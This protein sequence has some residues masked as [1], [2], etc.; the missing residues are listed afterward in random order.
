MISAH[1]DTPSSKKSIEQ[2]PQIKA[3]E[4]LSLFYEIETGGLFSNK[5]VYDSTGPIPFPKTYDLDDKTIEKDPDAIGKL[6]A[7]YAIVCPGAEYVEISQDSSDPL[8][9]VFTIK[10][11]FF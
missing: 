11:T 10:K 2:E 7:K 4:Q 9:T 5:L 6:L 1:W 8:V 3:P